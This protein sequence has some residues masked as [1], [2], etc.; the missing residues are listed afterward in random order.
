MTFP[1]LL[2]REDFIGQPRFA[3]LRA[4][5]DRRDDL[6]AAVMLCAGPEAGARLGRALDRL[7]V[8]R[9]VD[10]AAARALAT[11]LEAL[12]AS[13]PG[14]LAEIA[15]DAAAEVSDLA[16]ELADALRTAALPAAD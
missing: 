2:A 10:G 13:E 1:H 8:E 7:A 12:Q 3:A 16:G 6:I 5:L 11:A 14:A 9:I 15:P 4:V